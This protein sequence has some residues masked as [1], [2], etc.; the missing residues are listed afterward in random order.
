MP[1]TKT[2]STPPSSGSG[3]WTPERIE[4]M[5]RQDRASSRVRRQ[6]GQIVTG[7]DHWR[8]SQSSMACFS[9]THG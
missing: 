4:R 7:P 2:T 8:R 9:T 5:R 1:A 3:E 6:L